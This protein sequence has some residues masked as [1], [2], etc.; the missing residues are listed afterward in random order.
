MYRVWGKGEDYAGFW[1]GNL[2]ARDYLRDP[3]VDEII[4]TW[5]FS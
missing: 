3:G 4:L 5:F 1:S 2:R